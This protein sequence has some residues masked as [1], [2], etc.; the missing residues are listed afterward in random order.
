MIT[1]IAAILVAVG[2]AAGFLGWQL[3]GRAA[4]SLRV[5]H[6]LQTQEAGSDPEPPSASD[7]EEIIQVLSEAIELRRS[8]EGILVRVETDVRFLGA[9]QERAQLITTQAGEQLAAIGASLA[10]SIVASK[11][12]VEGLSDLE[13]GLTRSAQLAEA[14]AEELEELDRKMGPS[15]G[16]RP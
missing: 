12:S 1:K 8:I 13:R 2:V 7:N 3:Q 14:I 10:G 6:E 5:A 4:H 15:L 9:Q 11:G 16:G